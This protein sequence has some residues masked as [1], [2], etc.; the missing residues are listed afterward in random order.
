MST[1]AAESLVAVLAGRLPALEGAVAIPGGLRAARA[2][3]A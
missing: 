1:G 2:S 3:A